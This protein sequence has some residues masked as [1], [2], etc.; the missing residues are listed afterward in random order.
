M[1]LARNRGLSF[2]LEQLFQHQT[3]QE[4]ARRLVTDQRGLSAFEQGSAFDLV[5]SDDRA[6]LP[7]GIVDAYPL[8]EL[9]AGML[10]HSAYRPETAIYHNIAS[11]HLKVP[12]DIDKLDTALRELAECHAV[13]RTAFDLT[14]FSEPLQF[15]YQSVRVPLRVDD[16]RHLNIENKKKQS[17]IGLKMKSRRSSTGVGPAPAVSYSSS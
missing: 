15:V 1:S 9:Q 3:I 13:L 8:T 5:S 10:F 17:L 6:G 16:L 11:F 4:L 12:F 7:E 2:T 14:G